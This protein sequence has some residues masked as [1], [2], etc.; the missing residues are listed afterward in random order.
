MRAEF[1]VKLKRESLKYKEKIDA[2][3]LE[4][5]LRMLGAG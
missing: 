2:Q 3:F 1:T 5:K 4:G